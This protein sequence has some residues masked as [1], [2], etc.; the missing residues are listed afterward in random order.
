VS[1]NWSLSALNGKRTFGDAK[2]M[3]ALGSKADISKCNRHVRFIPENW[4]FKNAIGLGGRKL[5]RM[6][7]MN[8]GK[9]Q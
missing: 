8:V 6:G 9:R 2:Q 4:T 5:S 1:Y 3:P 7:D